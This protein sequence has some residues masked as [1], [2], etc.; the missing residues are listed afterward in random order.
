MSESRASCTSS[1]LHC[2]TR[3]PACRPPGVG[4]STFGTVTPIGTRPA[5]PNCA[6]N[7]GAAR[8]RI[9]TWTGS[10]SSSRP[11]QAHS[12][13]AREPAATSRAHRRRLVRPSLLPWKEHQQAVG[14]PAHRRVPVTRLADRPPLARRLRRPPG[15]ERRQLHPP[16]SAGRSRQSRSRPNLITIADATSAQA[17]PRPVSKLAAHVTLSHFRRLRRQQPRSRSPCP[18]NTPQEGRGQVTQTPSRRLMM[19]PIAGKYGSASSSGS[20][21]HTGHL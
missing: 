12:D 13:P 11:A 2:R 16:P 5:S 8:N 1:S 10:S 4:N 9:S 7:E 19:N 18:V 17:P 15:R 3:A 20:A 21:D 14:P 6:S